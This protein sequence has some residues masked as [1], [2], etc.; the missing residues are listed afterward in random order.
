MSLGMFNNGLKLNGTQQ[1]LA[2][3]EGTN[4]LSENVNVI[5]ENTEV[6]HWLVREFDWSLK[7]HLS[8]VS[9]LGPT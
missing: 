2:Y 5:K 4:T 9:A 3:A 7:L 8:S 1:L 6:C